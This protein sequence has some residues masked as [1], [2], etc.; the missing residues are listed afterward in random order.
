MA[1][2]QLS[3]YAWKQVEM[4]GRVRKGSGKWWQFERADGR[5]FIM[6][7]VQAF[8]AQAEKREEKSAF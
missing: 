2:K 3:E 4:Q 1:K 6:T 5:K 8:V 7:E